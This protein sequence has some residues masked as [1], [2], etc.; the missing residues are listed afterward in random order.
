MSIDTV[1]ILSA[2]AIGYMLL[3]V[4]LNKMDMK[5]DEL[6]S[7]VHS[8]RD[9]ERLQAVLGDL[10]ELRSSVRAFYHEAHY[11]L[12]LELQDYLEDENGKQRRK[13][14]QRNYDINSSLVLRRS[15]GSL[16]VSL[17]SISNILDGDSVKT[18][19]LLIDHALR[20]IRQVES[21]L[22]VSRDTASEAIRDLGTNY[23]I[24]EERY[25]FHNRE[26]MAQEFEPLFEKAEYR[27]GAR[28]GE[29]T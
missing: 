15:I 10:K 16:E 26:K 29:I 27:L 23:Q 3:L 19:S 7:L 1:A 12:P 18:V 4:R 2:T 8:F 22:E 11:E 24:T 21:W 13:W 9:A 5:V 28:V 17:S 20:L 6:K 14:M 25:P